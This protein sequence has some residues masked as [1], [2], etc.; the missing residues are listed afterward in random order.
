VTRR[1]GAGEGGVHKRADGRW[2]ARIDVGYGPNG[3][4]RKSV[5][6]ATKLEALR[7]LDEERT[8]L[9]NGLAPTDRRMTT[10]QFLQWWADKV[11]PGTVSAGSLETY[12]HHV[13]RYLIPG[14]G[15][16]R[17][18]ELAPAHVTEFMRRMESG[19]LSSLGRPLSAQTQGQA[20]KVLSK[21]LRRAEQ[22]G[23]VHRN[24]AALADPPRME[25]KEGRSLP[26][27]DARRLVAAM[28]EHRLRTAFLLQF[29]LGL[30]RGEVLG[31]RWSDVDLEQPATVRV[32]TQI[33]RRTGAGL[34]LSELKTR[35]S[36]RDLRLPGPMVAELR[37][38]AARQAAER[39]ALGDAW[40]D[41]LGLVF[42]TPIGTP[43][44]PDSYAHAFSTVAEAAGLGHW[45][46][47]ALRHCAGSILHAAGVP[48]KVISEYLGHAS[49]HITA[50]V[51]VHT[52]QAQRGHTA[53][54]MAAALWGASDTDHPFVGGQLG[55]QPAGR[56]VD[57][58]S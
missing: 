31:L 24:V 5:Y 7:K 17:L 6:G 46:T 36:R 4:Q 25:H 53:E 52:E 11:L 9:A 19:E 44:D 14:L 42:T 26:L 28:R 39:L 1:R 20:R 33:Q 30:R 37:A 13:A 15:R 21:A 51:Y 55:G 49:E 10:G 16:V 3:R 8:R 40:R 34:Q 54:A 45:T 32:R 43:V 57:S 29:S 56:G 58:G 48:L 23:L 41:R 12:R 27:E 50:D 38:W 18:A 47:H 35:Q 2:E 22:E